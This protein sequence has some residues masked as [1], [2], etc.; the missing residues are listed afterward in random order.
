MP[1][2]L[3]DTNRAAFQVDTKPAEAQ[4]LTLDWRKYKRMQLP[5]YLSR[6]LI[7]LSW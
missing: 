7:E 2:T 4:A 1:P 3:P 5:L 6:V